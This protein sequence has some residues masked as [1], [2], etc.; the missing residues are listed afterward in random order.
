MILRR[1]TM[2]AVATVIT[3]YASAAENAHR[4][5]LRSVFERAPGVAGAV[6]PGVAEESATTVEVLLA[7]IGP[8]GKLIKVCVDSEAAARRFF[9]APADT[10]HTKQAK[11]Q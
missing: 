2:A 6:K 8:D 1:A 7:R 3:V 9:E 4:L 11:E 5:D 10:L